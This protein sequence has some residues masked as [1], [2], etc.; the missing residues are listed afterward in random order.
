MLRENTSNLNCAQNSN[1]TLMGLVSGPYIHRP[2]Y[3]LL[4][5]FLQKYMNTLLCTPIMRW[6]WGE[7]Y[8][9]CFLTCR[10]QSNLCVLLVKNISSW[11]NQGIVNPSEMLLPNGNKRFWAN[12]GIQLNSRNIYKES[13]LRLALGSQILDSDPILDFGIG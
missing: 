4:V 8:L 6:L 12:T 3:G 10:T 11:S 5:F 9:A 2:S 7:C 13:I 1:W